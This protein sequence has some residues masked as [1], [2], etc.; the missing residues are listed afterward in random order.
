MTPQLRELLDKYPPLDEMKIKRRTAGLQRMGEF[1]Q[2]QVT[3][4]PQARNHLFSGFIGCLSYAV[5]VIGMYRNL[6]KELEK[7]E[8]K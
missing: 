8:Q 2:S 5:T 6:R 7:L 4:S 3:K 1:Y